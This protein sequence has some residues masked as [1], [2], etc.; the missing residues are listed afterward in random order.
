MIWSESEEEENSLSLH[1]VDKQQS[2]MLTKQAAAAAV[3]K[4]IKSTKTIFNL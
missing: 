2:F 4:R 1:T 3:M